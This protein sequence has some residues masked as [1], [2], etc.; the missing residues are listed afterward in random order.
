MVGSTI[1]AT[2]DKR[3]QEIIELVQ[4]IVSDSYFIRGLSARLDDKEFRYAVGNVINSVFLRINNALTG[5]RLGIST[6]DLERLLRKEENRKAGPEGSKLLELSIKLLDKKSENVVSMIQNLDGE[7]SEG[8]F[9][10]LE[11]RLMFLK[12]NSLVTSS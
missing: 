12:D 8:T 11:E 6:S 1:T 9:E 2:S 10:G 5:Q 3:E 7:M 4:Q